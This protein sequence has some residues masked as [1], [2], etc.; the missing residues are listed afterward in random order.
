MAVS[1][2]NPPTARLLDITRLISR[3]GRGP[4]T[5][6]DRV[7]MAYLS[8]LSSDSVPL[9]LL[10]RSSLGFVLLGGAAALPLLNRLAGAEPWGA[11]DLLS[12]LARIKAPAR[13]AA[14]ADLR[15]LSLDRCSP[16]G[17]AGMLR[18]HLPR[19]AAYLNVGHS[20][21]GAETLAA[22]SQVPGI[23]IAVLIHDTIP[24]DH[25]EFSRRGMPGRFAARLAAVG[26]HADLVI[27]NSHATAADVQRNLAPRGRVPA[28]V[29][30][31]LGVDPP[32][33]DFVALPKR[34][35][36]GRPWFVTVGTI[37]P[38]KNHA[39]LLKLWEE[40]STEMDAP[41]LLYILGRRGWRNEDVFRVLDTAPFMGRTVFEMNDLPDGGVAALTAGARALLFPSLAE[42]YGLPPLEAAALGVPVLASDLAVYREVLGDFGVYLDGGDPYPW[43]KKIIELMRDTGTAGSTET[44]RMAVPTWENH[45]DTVL[46]RT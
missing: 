19:G 15:R 43:R 45:F 41:P 10:A 8:R 4:L 14:E 7:E 13:A 2:G 18:K 42:G 40:L 30:A 22:I 25:P 21:L 35:A 6:V 46:K 9:F 31:H 32:C 38:R 24:L 39:L 44:A 23:R 12:R 5:G 26:A 16:A 34:P 29:T 28:L 20:N 37:E 27:C 17:L 1:T 36:P 11:A 33:P 3:V